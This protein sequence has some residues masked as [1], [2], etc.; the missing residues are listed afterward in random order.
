MIL[1]RL[2]K[3]LK[4]KADKEQA[5]LLARF[6]KTGPGEYG[7]G[8]KFLGIKVPILRQLAKQYIQLDFLEL[9]ELLLSNYHE[10]RMVAL[11]ILVYR[12]KKGDDITRRKIYNFYIKNWRAINN[13]DLVD[14]TTPNIMGEYLKKKDKMI[15]YD[16]VKS[17]NLW[18]RRMSIIATAAF[19]REDN[20]KDTFAI[21]KLLLRDKHD[22]IHKA[23]G[24]MLREVGNRSRKIEE[25]F[26][27]RW[28]KEMP[29]TMLRYAIEKFPEE[30]RKKY[31]HGTI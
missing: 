19:I 4:G 28:Y 11:Q 9:Q 12:F 7:H 1:K 2:K 25:T 18:K 31:L 6:F 15:L 14:T 27:R 26:L 24:W 29:R 30:Q 5:K 8:D 22:L 3:E 17:S 13:W 20:F 23:V 16:W 21:S 10:E